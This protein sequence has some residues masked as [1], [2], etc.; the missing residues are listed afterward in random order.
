M[1]EDDFSSMLGLVKKYI[2]DVWARL[3]GKNL[4]V[5]QSQCHNSSGELWDVGD[6]G[7]LRCLHGKLDTTISCVCTFNVGSAQC[8]GREWSMA[9]V[10]WLSFKY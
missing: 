7:R 2:V 9:L 3:Y 10:L 5:P 4:S 1:W 8:P 6:D